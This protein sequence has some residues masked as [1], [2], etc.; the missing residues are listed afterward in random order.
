MPDV[1]ELYMKRWKEND[2]DES[3]ERDAD[4]FLDLEKKIYLKAFPYNK[5]MF[6][7]EDDDMDEVEIV[8]EMN[9]SSAARSKRK[10]AEEDREPALEDNRK[11]AA[12]SKET[13]D[14]EQFIGLDFEDQL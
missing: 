4:A 10:T 5:A 11:P 13:E 1:K 9:K 3:E 12:K 8:E 14:E 2:W 6:E 7:D